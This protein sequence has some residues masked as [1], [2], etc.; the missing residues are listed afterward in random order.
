MT[1]VLAA[2]PLGFP[3]N[4]IMT[5]MDASGRPQI[6][7]PSLQR[8]P[9][10][11][12]D[13]KN[14]G[15]GRSRPQKDVKDG[16]GEGSPDGG[17]DGHS[18]G[19]DGPSRKRRRS[20]KGLDKKFECPQEGFTESGKPLSAH[21]SSSPE[22]MR[23]NL[24]G[25]KSRTNQLQYQSPTEMNPNSYS[26]ATLPSGA[27]S[28]TY[29]GTTSSNGA[30]SYPPTNNFKRSNSDSIPQRQGS[31]STTPN[32]RPQR[33]ASFGISD[34]KPAEFSRPPL[35]TNV[36]PYGLL[37]GA[38]GN[39]N[40]H[41][42]QSSPQS[43][44]PQQNFA[45]FSLPPPGFNTVAT[46]AAAREPEPTY[47]TSM[48]TEYQNDSMPQNSG[49]DMMLLDQMTAPNTM[50]VFGGEGYSRSP[51]A[52]PEDFVAYLFSEQQLNNNSSPM[53]QM[54]QQGYANYPDNPNQYYAPFYA[55]DMGLGGF[56]P[57]NQ[58]PHHP[59]A[60]TSLLDTSQPE[61]V[62]SEEKSQAIVD[63]I[64]D[65]FNEGDHAPVARQKEALMEGDRSVD[66]HLLSRKMMQTYIG[67]YWYNFSEQVPILH[68]PTF[69]PDKTPNLL[70]ISMM[71]IGAACLD[72]IHGY[73]LT[74]N[75]AELSNFLA[76]HLR[77]EIFSD[78]HFR[79]PAKLWVFQALL[80]LEI[81]EKMYS[82]RALHERAHIHHATTITLMRRGSSLIGR[83]A[84]DSPPSVREDKQGLNGSRQS[85]TSGANTPDEWW[86][87]WITNEATRRAAFAAFVI[88]STHATMFGHSTVMVA[89]E[90]RLPL[91]C[92]EA[93]WSANNSA[94]VG[95]IEASL[96]A[97]GVKPISFLEGLKRTLNAQE[98]RTN[99]FGR[100]I[101]MA[102]LLSVSWHMN[103]RDLQVN[104]LGVSQALGGR[105]KWRGSLTRAFDLWKQD[106]DRSLNRNSETIPGPYV[107]SGKEE[108]NIV[109]QGRTVLH[110]LAHMAMHVDIVDCQIF[111][112]AKRLLG[113]TI[114]TQD[115]NSAQRRMKDN[116]APTAKARD[117]TWY[118][119]RFLCDVLLPKES[120]T[121]GMHASYDD[122]PFEY[123]ARDDSLL[124]R[125][126]VLYFAALIV[127]CYGF[128]LEGPTT[129]PVPSAYDFDDQVRHMRSY[130]RRLGGIRSP[131]ELKTM[132]GFNGCTGM[133]MVLRTTFEKTRWELLHE[134]AL[135]LNNC[136]QLIGGQGQQT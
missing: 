2:Q 10:T 100:T 62:L 8:R 27:S 112:R 84:L 47:P 115:L 43:F 125:P 135:L 64:K 91:P 61:M 58:Q 92:D 56:F 3:T 104:S 74:Q 48:P 96:H 123:S 73:E 50:P 70:L 128:A 67:S 81:Y 18:S 46:S 89:H 72:K 133:L 131:E 29:S 121:S 95:R 37:S 25:I 24:A 120:V 80:L 16:S 14:R 17:G 68:K 7:D 66:S 32:N 41:G 63:L 23:P 5:Q 26:P 51:F 59:M 98:V 117:A 13:E 4:S 86:N 57:A 40:Y 31:A 45:P 119:L 15:R 83:S 35:Q 69:S 52:I 53:G 93:L 134:A 102:G 110:H 107:Y 79:P 30:D 6:L 132:R 129:D 85:S 65:R 49:P 19:T 87:H 106:F 109:F 1:S 11:E 103:Q 44:V 54:G 124:N 71:A 33:H 78:Y 28:G 77:W 130:L 105:D 42:T 38:S 20:R 101:L 136:I 34:G 75:C 118:A 111:A 113:R 88:D 99:S 127:W 60:V 36:G 94:E 126:W 108:G 9:K 97:N 39:Q 116:W 90:M 82:T 76:W 12:A 55:G 114:G 122:P 22:V 21:G